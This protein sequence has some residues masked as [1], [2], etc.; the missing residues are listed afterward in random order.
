[1]I[2]RPPRST[3]SSSSAASDVYKRQYQR[4]VREGAIAMK[5]LRARATLRKK[6]QAEGDGIALLEPHDRT[7]D[8]LAG[9]QKRAKRP[10]PRERLA[11]RKEAGKKPSPRDRMRER[12]QELRGKGKELVEVEMEENQLAMHSN[13]EGPSLFAQI[14]DKPT[15]EAVMALP[16]GLQY[17]KKY[18]RS[19]GDLDLVLFYFEVQKYKTGTMSRT[20]RVR[21]ANTILK[22]YLTNGGEF[23]LRV[24]D[25][26]KE[27]AREQCEA[28]RFDSFDLAQQEALRQLG[29]DVFPEYTESQCFEE[30]VA[31]TNELLFNKEA[32]EETFGQV[33][34]QV[35][36]LSA[37]VDSKK[38]AFQKATDFFHDA[39]DR[40]NKLKDRCAIF[41]DLLD[42]SSAYVDTM[43]GQKPIGAKSVRWNDISKLR[44]QMA[45]VQDLSLIHIS[46]PTRLLSISYAVFCLKKKKKTKIIRVNLHKEKETISKSDDKLNIKLKKI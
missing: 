4:R 46:E 36:E 13:I 21:S 20:L 42:A 6:T 44:K 22:K 30:Y 9:N 7:E 15:L 24:P 43:G 25:S 3:L 41:S 28:P 33:N 19:S 45:T 11:Q 27:Q 34:K 5:A 16:L 26:L 32:Q 23:D 8:L 17:F 39:H 35:R 1:M 37:Q 12:A 29:D 18:C 10:S 2:R 40:L 31:V 38:Q 14:V